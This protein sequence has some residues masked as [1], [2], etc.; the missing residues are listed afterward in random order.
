MDIIELIIDEND[1]FSGIDAISI[2]EAPAIEENFVALAEQKEYKFAE[3]DKEQQILIW[4]MLIPNKP[5]YRREGEKE[6]YIYF[7]K[8]T[9][10]KA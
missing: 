8:E 7:I 5:I 10:R 3:I 4:P 1:E 2:V 9:V 6:Y